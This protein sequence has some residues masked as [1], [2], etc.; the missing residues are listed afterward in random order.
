MKH[1][2]VIFKVGG[3]LKGDASRFLQAEVATYKQIFPQVYLLK[4]RNER[5]DEDVQNLI[6]VALKTGNRV[7]LNSTDA[8][9]SRLLKNLYTEPIRL[10]TAIFTDELAPVEYYNSSAQRFH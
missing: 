7:M 4:V 8:E 6:I 10:E 1:L 9:V 2:H 3:A 5:A